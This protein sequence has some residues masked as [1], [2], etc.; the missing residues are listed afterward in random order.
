MVKKRFVLS[1]GGSGG[2]LYP[3]ITIAKEILKLEPEAK[4][5]YIGG[6]GRRESRI[7][8]RYGLD[9]VPVN[10]ESFPRS[11]SLRWFKVAWNVPMGLIQSMLVLRKFS[12][13]V[14]IGTG[15]YV[16]GPVLLGAILLHI[17]ILIQEQNAMPGVTNRILGRWATEIYIPFLTAAKFFPSGRTRITGNPVRPEIATAPSG[18]E[19]FGLSE[20]KLTISFVGGSQGS[21]SINAAAIAALKRMTEFS[22]QIQ[23]IH[24][25]GERDFQNIKKVYDDLPFT[26]VVQPYFDSI[27]YVYSSTDLIVCR[28]GATT[29]AEITVRGLPAVLIPHP[30]GQTSQKFNAE[31]VKKSGAAVVIQDNQL[32]GERLAD[33]LTPL[34]GDRE[35]LSEMGRNSR[36][37]GNSDAAHEIAERAL[38]F[39]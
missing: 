27:E 8:P 38:L 17:P 19:K 22:P 35:K 28:S 24:Q 25:T 15:G 4:I 1:G 13:R 34:I 23:I 12:P 6:K 18:R 29:L 30:L 16:C 3:A 26:A 32:N 20:D 5:L 9:F 21:S 33:T 14:V 7:V 37:L 11:L 31:V 36:S 2:H 39:A 10:V